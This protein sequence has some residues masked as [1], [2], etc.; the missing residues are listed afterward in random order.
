MRRTDIKAL[1][2]LSVAGVP[3]GAFLRPRLLSAR[4]RRKCFLIYLSIYILDR[5]TSLASK[6]FPIFGL[7]LRP[8]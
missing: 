8:D 3:D 5:A 7:P 4:H 6:L 1:F 2:K